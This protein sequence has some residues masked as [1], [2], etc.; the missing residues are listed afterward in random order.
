MVKFNKK[1]EKMNVLREKRK[2]KAG[3]IVLS[4]IIFFAVILGVCAVYLSNYYRA[5]K[6]AIEAFLPKGYSWEE[7]PDG[8]IIFKPE[9]A[10]TGFI[11][12][13]GGKVEYTSYIPLMQ[14]CSEQGI[15]CVLV[16]M[17]FNLAVLD[18][19]A[20]EGIQEQYPQIENWYIGGHSLGG[21]MAA[22]YLS[23]H[24]E[25]F[26]GLVLLGAYS[27]ADLSATDLKVLSVYG[28]EDG[29]MNQKKYNKNKGNLPLDFTEN[30][31]KGGCH[32]YFGMYGT[33]DGDGIPAITNE[34]QI[35]MTADVIV[36]M[37]KC[38][39]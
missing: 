31:I 25:R 6:E 7:E 4:V 27:T 28:S 8:T 16:K 20:A 2:R 15:L 39:R 36:E 10:N 17:P 35:R 29:V 14:V 32:A 19:N 34:E 1:G 11:F 26:K 24:K 37:M 21:S 9:Q 5:D 18:V 12:Y 30:I 23:K 22:A 38:G 33:Q 13:P 3:M